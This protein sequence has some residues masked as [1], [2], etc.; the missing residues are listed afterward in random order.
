MDGSILVPTSSSDEKRFVGMMSQWMQIWNEFVPVNEAAAAG[1][2]FED[3][4]EILF[5]AMAELDHGF[6]AAG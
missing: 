6:V 3:K 2:L 5:E 1:G 4:V